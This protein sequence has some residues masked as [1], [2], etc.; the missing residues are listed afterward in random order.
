MH[1]NHRALAA[2]IL[3]DIPGGS[4]RHQTGK[5]V[6]I[7]RPITGDRVPTNAVYRRAMLDLG[8][9]KADR[10]WFVANPGRTTLGDDGT[11]DDYRDVMGAVKENV[12]RTI[13][14]IR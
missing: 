2:K 4:R 7:D 8:A 1:A 5:R 9:A 13:S 14:S 12:G 6:R 10:G 11:A 3:A